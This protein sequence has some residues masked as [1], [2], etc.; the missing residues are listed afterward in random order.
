MASYTI[1]A[2]E[3]GSFTRVSQGPTN[4][5]TSID[6]LPN[7]EGTSW[8]V[9]PAASFNYSGSGEGGGGGSTRPT[10]GFLYPRGQG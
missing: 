5:Y 9:S 4:G 1:P 6:F 3:I 8:L 10:S 7:D 2:T